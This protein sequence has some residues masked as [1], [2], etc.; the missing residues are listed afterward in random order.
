MNAAA[1]AITP[2][3]AGEANARSSRSQPEHLLLHPCTVKAKLLCPGQMRPEAGGI[4]S[5]VVDVLGN[6]DR[7]VHHV[8]LKMK[9]YSLP[10]LSDFRTISP[11]LL[12]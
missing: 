10:P 3:R 1:P 2:K 4:E 7:E 6:R 5:V 9:S 11:R 8:S 12:L